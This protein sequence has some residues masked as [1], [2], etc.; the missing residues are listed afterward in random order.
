MGQKMYIEPVDGKNLIE[1]YL[2]RKKA[3]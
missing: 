1:K 2:M 3:K